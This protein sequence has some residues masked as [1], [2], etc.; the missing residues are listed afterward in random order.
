MVRTYSSKALD[1]TS[2]PSAALLMSVS[3]YLKTMKINN[4]PS[5]GFTVFYS[6]DLLTPLIKLAEQHL[7][8]LLLPGPNDSDY[9]SIYHMHPNYS[10]SKLP[11]RVHSEKDVERWVW[12]G[13]W[14]PAF[15]AICREIERP[16]VQ[17]PVLRNQN[18]AAYMASAIKREKYPVPDGVTLI[19]CLQSQEGFLLNEFRAVLPLEVKV[20]NVLFNQKTKVERDSE[21]S[22]N[23]NPNDPGVSGSDQKPRATELDL[24]PD[25]FAFSPLQDMGKKFWFRWPGSD[26]IVVHAMR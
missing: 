12:D 3:P 1:S 20:N 4:E 16:F 24:N 5:L 19:R 25:A 7:K 11:N 2:P 9:A 8:N 6:K 26:A 23:K 14:L 18:K 21:E 17:D 15:L 22:G 10:T 13:I